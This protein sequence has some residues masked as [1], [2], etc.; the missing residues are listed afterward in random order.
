VHCFREQV[1]ITFRKWRGECGLNSKKFV[2][3]KKFWE[4]GGVASDGV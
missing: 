3:S 2:L 1:N 4:K